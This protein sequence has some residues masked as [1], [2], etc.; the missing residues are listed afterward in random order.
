M[1]SP[2][3]PY[4]YR[5]IS[6]CVW[7]IL[8]LSLSCSEKVPQ[9]KNVLESLVW[10]REKEVDR[11]RER[12]Q[13]ARALQ[14]AKASEAK[15]N[16]RDL[17]KAVRE[18]RMLFLGSHLS[19]EPFIVSFQAFSFLVYCYCYYMYF[20]LCFPS[21]FHYGFSYYEYFNKYP[22]SS[23]Y[24]YIYPPPLFPTPFPHPFSPL[25]PPL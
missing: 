25:P 21:H 24:R 23:F 16:K 3:Q 13:L 2:Y 19:G 1:L 15:N 22:F 11:M 6:I 5:T 10:D 4:L 12:F 9:P 18:V 17:V 7:S 14:Q 8:S 20:S